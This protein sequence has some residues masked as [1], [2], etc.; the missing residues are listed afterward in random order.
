MGIE[1][2]DLMENEKVNSFH[3]EQGRRCREKKSRCEGAKASAPSLRACRW[4]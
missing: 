2:R 3:E 4:I 1:A